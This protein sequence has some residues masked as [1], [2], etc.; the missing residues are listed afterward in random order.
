MLGFVSYFMVMYS[1]PQ[2][3]KFIIYIKYKE[4]SLVILQK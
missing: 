3:F 2:V 4:D 1:I